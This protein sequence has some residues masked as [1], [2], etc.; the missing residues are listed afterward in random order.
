MA[1]VQLIGDEA[2][3]NT[4]IEKSPPKKLVVV[5]IFADWC[6]VCTHMNQHYDRLSFTFKDLGTFLKVNVDDCP[7]ISGTFGISTLPTFVLIQGGKEVDRC[8]GSATDLENK[9]A[10]WTSNAAAM[11]P[12]SK[13]KA[14]SSSNTAVNVKAFRGDGHRLGDKKSDVS[15]STKGESGGES[16]SSTTP[17]K[18][19][20]TGW[21]SSVANWFSYQKQDAARG[22][23]AQ[24]KMKV[25]KNLPQVP[26]QI[27]LVDSTKLQLILNLTQPVSKIR[28]FILIARPD[29]AS[30]KF[31]L[32]SS[33]PRKE[34]TNETMSIGEADLGHALVIQKL[35]KL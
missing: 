16:S 17:A 8:G 26:I 33:F 2:T 32:L 1:V 27:R 34:I 3:L 22:V 11:P 4:I 15:T 12:P 25:D 24:E 30:K 18:N 13:P 28:E 21:F 23:S 9:I 35:A 19:A 10:Q 29:F 31:I 5:D 14:G 7:S 20:Q 6:A